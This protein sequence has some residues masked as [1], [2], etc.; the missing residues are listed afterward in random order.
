MDVNKL[1]D[2]LSQIEIVDFKLEDI[3]EMAK[4]AVTLDTVNISL[5]IELIN[6]DKLEKHKATKKVE[7]PKEPGSLK[8]LILESMNGGMLG[9]NIPVECVSTIDHDINNNT[10]LKILDLLHKDLTA[11][12]KQLLGRLKRAKLNI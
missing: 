6:K 12:R 1:K 2:L 11:H 5:F 10:V 3:N 7:E 9:D 8:E 4:Q